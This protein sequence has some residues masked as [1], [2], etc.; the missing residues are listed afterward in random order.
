MACRSCVSERWRELTLR[1]A[2]RAG[3]GARFA[4]RE[5]MQP[6]NPGPSEMPPLCLRDGDVLVLA[7][8]F[9]KKLAFHH[10]KAIDGFSA[11]ARTKILEHKWA[12]DVRELE[13]A[14]ERAVL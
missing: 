1:P 12:G 6:S 7:E 5:A 11:E 13:S 3:G 4:G 8:H 10:L 9:L 2:M 14:I